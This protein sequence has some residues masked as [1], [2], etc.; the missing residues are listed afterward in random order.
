MAGA[1]ELG[2]LGQLPFRCSADQVRTFRD[3]TRTLSARWAEHAV[4][5]QKPMLEFI[6]PGLA[7]ASLT[8]FF[9]VSLGIKPE[10]GLQRLQRMLENKLYK[11]LIVG[12]EELGRYV[13][14][15]ISETR[16]HHTGQGVCL[17][18]EATVQ[19]KEW[20]G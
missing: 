18:A 4:I 11:T 20:G 3:L 8:L 13:I 6:G 16:K 15:N 12:G 2:S 7:T 5:G 19:L 14:E 1:S 17:S 9:D 10:E